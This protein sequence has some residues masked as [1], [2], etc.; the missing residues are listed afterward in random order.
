MQ[1]TKKDKLGAGA[2]TRY[3]VSA[4]I[5]EG[6]TL[7]QLS[8]ATGMMIKAISRFETGERK[9]KNASAE[10]V[11]KLAKAL[12]VKAEELLL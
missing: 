9:L 11:L 12:G 8:E 2:P 6:M 4:L 3:Q 7:K 10:T 1:P 5:L